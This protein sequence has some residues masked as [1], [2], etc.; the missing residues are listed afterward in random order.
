MA[1]V[2]QVNSATL[3]IGPTGSGKSSLARTLAEYLWETWQ[4][5]LYY[6][7]CD[8][9]GYP[10]RV[11]EGIALGIIKVF[12]MRT[13]DPG[14]LNLAF[15]TCYRAAQ[16]W[17]P[18]RINPATGEVE[19]GVEMVPPIAKRIA[20]ICPNGHVVKHVLL[21][22]QLTPQPCPVCNTLVTLQTMTTR[23]E[24]THSKGFEDRGGV[25]FDGLTSMLSWEMLE[26]GQR[27][28]R[29]ELGGEEGAI[30]GKVVS[31]ELRFGGTTRSHVGFAQSR[32]EEL[33]HLALGV[34]NL[35]VPPIFTAL[36]D[37]TTDDAA[38]P[39]VGP[40]IAGHAKTDEAPQ[41]V[42][43]CLEA[44]KRPNPQGAGEQFVLLLEEFTD[45]RGRKHMIKHRGSPGTMPGELADPSDGSAPFSKFNLGLFFR[46]LDA[47]LQ[48]GIAQARVQYPDAPG[49]S[50]AIE[51]FGDGG[52]ATSAQPTG[53]SP[54][55]V[56]RPPTLQAPPPQG[57]VATPPSGAATS[58]VPVTP[59]PAAPVTLAAPV[60]PPPVAA[61]PVVPPVVAPKTRSTKTKQPPA[62]ATPPPVVP[63]PALAPVAQQAGPPTPLPQPP[64][65]PATPAPATPAIP[66]A[67]APPAPA[68]PAAPRRGVAPPPGVRPPASTLAAPAAARPPAPPAA[69]KA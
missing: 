38:L 37:E 57:L 27:S 69:P 9:G 6:Y 35:L 49:V 32:G 12:R 64:A 8:G 66:V 62:P 23:T 43:N 22:T 40:K 36:T 5:K 19:P 52:Q 28:G 30:G 33:C 47:A 65:P 4:K 26:L 50:D 10:A 67:P 14:H 39:I 56:G 29:L 13:R 41:W 31:G 3:I 1:P 25:F 2:S 34:P 42:G 59:P 46:M 55:V 68:A 51:E 7:T 44:T 18:R 48:A 24:L 15:E 63:A 45:G 17:W 20:Q 61:P 21:T 16:G 53:H 11:Q 58:T 60:T 54:S